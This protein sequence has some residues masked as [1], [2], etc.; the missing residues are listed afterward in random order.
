[1]IV[2]KT[3]AQSHDAK[4]N[5]P[6]PIGWSLPRSGEVSIAGAII[7]ADCPLRKLL[8]NAAHGW[9]MVDLGR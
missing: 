5:G 3:V 1:M 7:M 9:L 2:L 4:V 6:V 8:G